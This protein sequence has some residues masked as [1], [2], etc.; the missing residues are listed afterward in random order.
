M[1]GKKEKLLRRMS[2]AQKEPW[3][4]FEKAHAP[5]GLESFQGVEFYLNSRYQVNVTKFMIDPPF[6]RCFHLSIKTRDKAPY[7]DWRDFQ[8]IKNELVGPEYEAVELYPAESRLMDTSNQYH[9][10]CFLD[11]KFPFGYKKREV[12]EDTGNTGAA[13]R[14]F[15]LKPEGLT[16]P[17]L[18]EA[19]TTTYEELYHGKKV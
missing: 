15:E 11:F 10:W 12:C 14:P 13:Q 2:V 7:H 6:G 19:L 5:R 4:P 17:D 18:R 3:T 9:I 16:V 8:R 1:G